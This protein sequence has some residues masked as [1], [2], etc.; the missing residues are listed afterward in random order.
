[1]AEIHF[2]FLNFNTILLVLLILLVGGYLYYE[3]Y[4]MKITINDIDVST[5]DFFFEIT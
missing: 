2:D 3:I 1:M 5:L 4:K